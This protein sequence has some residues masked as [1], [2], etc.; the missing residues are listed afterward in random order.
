MVVWD[1]VN[2]LPLGV[3]GPLDRAV[4]RSLIPLRE[5]WSPSSRPFALPRSATIGIYNLHAPYEISVN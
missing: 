3:A 1:E 5:R 2:N 4:S